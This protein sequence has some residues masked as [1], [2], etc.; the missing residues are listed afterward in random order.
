MFS[1]AQELK[2]REDKKIALYL[3]RLLRVK[4][5]E[6]DDTARCVGVTRIRRVVGLFIKVRKV[7]SEWERILG[8]AA[9][10]ETSSSGVSHATGFLKNIKLNRIY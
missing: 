3:L 2:L 4:S 7:R 6:T 5:V 1:Y 9:N 10:R 8:R